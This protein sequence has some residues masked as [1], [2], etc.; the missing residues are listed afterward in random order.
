MVTEKQGNLAGRAGG[1]E[2]GNAVGRS[3]RDGIGVEEDE[4]DDVAI[5]DSLYC[6]FT[7]VYPE[8]TAADALRG[9][10]YEIR[11]VFVDQGQDIETVHVFH[12]RD[13]A[14]PSYCSR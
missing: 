1:L 11:R 9:Q 6:R 8:G 13:S 12:S 14:S 10:A 2:E 7:A 4:V 5:L 3:H